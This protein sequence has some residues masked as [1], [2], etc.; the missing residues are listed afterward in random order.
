MEPIS[1]FD[2]LKIGVGPSS[3][4]TLGPW[5][6]AE[7]FWKELQAEGLLAATH[8]VKAHLYGSL[9]LTGVGHG[10]DIAV[11][12]GL[13]G[14]DPE[15]IPV[16]DVQR[17]PQQ[18]A[19]RQM[20]R[21]GGRHPISFDPAEAIEFH[22]S[23]RLPGHA[24]GLVFDAFDEHGERLHSGTYYSVGGGFVVK[25][26]EKKQENP[27]QLPHPIATARELAGYCASH[28]AAIWEVVMEN[29][30]TW[31]PASEVKA[32]LLRI[33]DVMK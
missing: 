16:E 21:L 10:T 29:E 17:I 28:H 8:R 26:G 19:A 23:E 25:E 9:A 14:Q 18:A 6:A 1:V 4:H 20:L 33:W 15:T 3:S 24:N 2:M 13:C 7:R 5:R 32:G 30:K 27:V 31:R 11:L 12:L 22:Y